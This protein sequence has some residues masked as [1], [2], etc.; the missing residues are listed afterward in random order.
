MLKKNRTVW[1][2]LALAA[3]LVAGGGL[4]TAVAQKSGITPQPD[5][6]ALGEDEAKRL[7]VL[8]DADKNGRVS[9]KEYMAFME[10]EFKRLDKDNNGYLDVKELTESTFRINQP[11][12]AVGK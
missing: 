12:S 6:V 1:L 2:N 5:K 3:A 8:M 4:G 9:K 7:L 10:A 11:S